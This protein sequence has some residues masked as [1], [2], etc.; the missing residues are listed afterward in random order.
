MNIAPQKEAK[1]P[2]VVPKEQP[3]IEQP[4]SVRERVPSD[5]EINPEGDIIVARN[6]STA[7][8]YKGTVADFNKLLRG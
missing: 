8:I 7:R 4:F 2:P 1:A 6:S 3:V 5:W